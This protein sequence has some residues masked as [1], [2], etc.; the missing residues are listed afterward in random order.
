MQR[1]KIFI[2]SILISAG[3]QAQ[4]NIQF[5]PALYGANIM[6]L[7]KAQIS[8]FYTTPQTGRVVVVVK[9]NA[10]DIVLLSTP[11]FIISTGN[12]FIPA[13]IF[14]NS[15][16]RYSN[17][18]AGNAV[19]QTGILPD[20]EYEY[21]FKFEIDKG[22]VPTDEFCFSH[23]VQNATPLLLIDPVDGDEICNRRPTFSWQPPIPVRPGTLYKIQLVA[24]NRKE[25]P[26]SAL[27]MRKPIFVQDNL[28]TPIYPFPNNAPDLEEGK[29]YA[30]QVLAYNATNTIRSEIW[31]FTVRCNENA[32][33]SALFS[34]REVKAEEDGDYYI[35]EGILRIYFKNPYNTANLKYEIVNLSKPTVAIKGLPRLKTQL[36]N[37]YYALDL[38]NN[39]YFID[40]NQYKINIILSNGQ[41]ISLKFL[42]K[43][44]KN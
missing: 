26:E 20:G 25:D 44:A 14:S 29:R 23:A 33:D 15:N 12:N 42:Y 35:A 22:N 41:K 21:C 38:D 7:G 8:S 11:L 13:T 36:G 40:G 39:K 30:W 27:L 32:S 4:V 3:L 24:L 6:G 9:Q 34:Y 5:Q 16:F 2:L 43:T 1:I 18:A 28:N 19:K 37:N 17:N 10:T 31:E